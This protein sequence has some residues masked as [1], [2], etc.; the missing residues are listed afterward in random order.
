MLQRRESAVENERVI[1]LRGDNVGEKRQDA[2]GDGKACVKIWLPS[3]KR[4]S[5]HSNP[6]RVEE[7]K[8]ARAP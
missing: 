3:R 8:Q 2:K 1:I 5:S 7:T 4:E 6:R